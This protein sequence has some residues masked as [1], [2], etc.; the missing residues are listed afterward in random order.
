MKVKTSEQTE[1]KYEGKDVKHL[2]S[3]HGVH[4]IVTYLALD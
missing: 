1:I 4:N 2:V 3:Y